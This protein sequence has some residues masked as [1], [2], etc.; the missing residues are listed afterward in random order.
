MKEH[1]FVALLDST[2]RK[3]KM[4]IT[5]S[6]LKKST[7][8]MTLPPRV[9]IHGLTGAGK[10]SF[11]AS[12]PTPVFASVE[13]NAFGKLKVDYQEIDSSKD[14]LGFT[15][16]LLKEQH[17]FKS[18]VLDTVDWMD[19]VIQQEV[20]DAEKVDG[21]EKVGGGYGKGYKAVQE[22]WI[23]IA[24]ALERLQV[25]KK[26]I[27]VLLA[28]S[29]VKTQTPP[30]SEPYDRWQLNVPDKTGTFLAEWSDIV[31]YLKGRITATEKQVGM[32]TVHKAIGKGDRVLLTSNH[33]AY[34]A[35]NRYS[36]P[37]EIP[38]GPTDGW[39]KLMEAYKSVKNG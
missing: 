36:L 20:C 18:F 38:V 13:K 31:G 30:D 33:P 28:H 6:S 32:K 27:V 11:G 5:L 21:I 25:E 15:A 39:T 16:M 22:R 3:K 14:L 7:G 23:K 12:C 34:L 2:E 17:E 24:D 26:M 37:T 10:T 4:A 1:S 35:K 29:I 9:I 8:E 19:K